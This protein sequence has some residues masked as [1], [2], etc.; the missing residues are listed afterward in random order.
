MSLQET[1]EFFEHYREAFNRFDGDAVADLWHV[2]GAIGVVPPDAAHAALTLWSDDA[3]MRANMHALCDIYRGHGDAHWD[4][5]LRDFVGM[6]AHQAF[7]RVHW[8]L[9]RD[10]GALVQEFD[11]GYN[12]TRTAQGPRVVLCTAFEEALGRDQ[13]K[14]QHAAQ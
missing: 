7:A 3:P 11:T 8:R 9:Q 10:D 14:T 1:T 12:L 13:R 5:E 6:G 2:P 4:F